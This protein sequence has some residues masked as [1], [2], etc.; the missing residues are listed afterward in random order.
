MSSNDS[1]NYKDWILLNTRNKNNNLIGKIQK[2]Y[3]YSYWS[4]SINWMDNLDS[5][6]VL[7]HHFLMKNYILSELDTTIVANVF[8]HD[9]E[10]IET[11]NI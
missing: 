3:L 5:I 2:L 4:L 9:Q 8:S 11:Y 6:V 10:N 1:N 7:F